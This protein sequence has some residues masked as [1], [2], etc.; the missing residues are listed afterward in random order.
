MRQCP[1]CNFLNPDTSKFC[2]RC[3]LPLH[4]SAPGMGGMP[5]M[6]P[7]PMPQPGKNNNMTIIVAVIGVAIVIL[8]AII[9]IA[10]IGRNDD[11]DTAADSSN[12]LTTEYVSVG[13]DTTVAAVASSA[14]TEVVAPAPAEPAPQPSN[15]F[16]ANGEID[17]YPYSV[18]GK[19][20]DGVMTGKYSNGKFGTRLNATA[21]RNGSELTIELSDGKNYYSRL[22]LYDQGGG[23]YD[24]SYYGDGVVKSASLRVK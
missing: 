9:A 17:G 23:R 20:K 11:K 15:S 12:V 13:I 2:N 6:P 4:P 1:K 19:W 7:S 3:G 5:P 18:T 22:E 14:P 16:S 10:L 21:Y 8:L 24:G